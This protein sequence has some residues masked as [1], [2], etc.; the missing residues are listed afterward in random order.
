MNPTT[1]D[2]TPAADL[3]AEVAALRHAADRVARLRR[4]DRV[5][6]LRRRQAALARKLAAADRRHRISKLTVRRAT[7]LRAAAAM[8]TAAG[9][10][11]AAGGKAAGKRSAPL[12]KAGTAPKT[13]PRHTGR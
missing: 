11:P 9:R 8:R 5:A 1:R 4:A 12:V 2:A 7:A 6:R 10:P 13:V 3:A